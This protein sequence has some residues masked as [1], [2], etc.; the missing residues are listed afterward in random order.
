MMTT[1]QTPG[2]GES[3]LESLLQS[4]SLEITARDQTMREAV[5]KRMPPGSEV[6]IA[7]LPDQP[8]EVLIEAAVELH[9]AGFRP[10]PHLVARNTESET[11][12]RGVL[13]RLRSKAEI[14]RALV[15]GGDRGAPMGPFRSGLDLIDS[16]LLQTHGISKVS[17]TCYP[18]GH[19]R[20]GR[21][22]LERALLE[23]LA[24]AGKDGFE[25][26]LVTQFAFDAEPILA[27]IRQLRAA[28]VHVPVRVGVAGPAPRAALVEFGKELGAGASMQDLEER[29]HRSRSSDE[30]EAP[31]RLLQEIARARAADPLL[32]IKGVHFFPFGSVDETISWTQARRG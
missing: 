15:T 9:R 4:F 3:L 8:P 17:L 31:S 14:D 26:L 20:I 28:G 18:E 6:Y 19:P 5:I 29:M 30:P 10:V 13:A 11:A 25:V 12:L 7:D 23:K 16:G 24:A 27:R 1:D 32:A 22:D 2:S 21:D